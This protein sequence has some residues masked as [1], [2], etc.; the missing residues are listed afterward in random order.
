MTLPVAGWGGHE[1]MQPDAMR[2]GLSAADVDAE[3]VL[4]GVLSLQRPPSRTRGV[5]P[6]DTVTNTTQ[7]LKKSP[8]AGRAG[9][10]T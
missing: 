9:I 10:L 3:D 6:K 2:L 1:Q 4:R 7:V 5:F 8:D